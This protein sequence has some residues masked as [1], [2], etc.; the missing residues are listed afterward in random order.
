MIIYDVG[1]QPQPDNLF[2]PIHGYGE[3]L[4]HPDPLR[5]DG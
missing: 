3:L 1:S 5:I 4:S 2:M